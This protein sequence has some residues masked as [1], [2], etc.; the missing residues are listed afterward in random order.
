MKRTSLEK[1]TALIGAELADSPRLARNIEASAAD[2]GISPRTLARAK[3]HLGVRSHK[4]R[5]NGAWVW[6]LA[7]TPSSSAAIA[8]TSTAASRSAAERPEPA[9]PAINAAPAEAPSH[10]T[11]EPA[12]PL[13]AAPAPSASGPAEAG[14]AETMEAVHQPAQAQGD[15]AVEGHAGSSGLTSAV[16]ARPRP[17]ADPAVSVLAAPAHVDISDDELDA[18]I[19]DAD[20]RLASRPT[21]APVPRAESPE[22]K[23][24]LEE[25]EE[26]EL[27]RFPSPF[28]RLSSLEE[29]PIP[30]ASAK[31]EPLPVGGFDDHEAFARDNLD[32]FDVDEAR[33]RDAGVVSTVRP[34]P[35]A[36]RPT[37]PAAAG[38]TACA[39][40]AEVGR[41]S[42]TNG[43]IGR[44]AWGLGPRLGCRFPKPG[45]KKAAGPV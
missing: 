42:V 32:E 22:P 24:D 31:G 34:S 25:S 35:T 15:V 2:A 26:P 13:P 3:R 43:N 5:G 27:A 41:L 19:A 28:D 14:A 37:M 30:W 16:D 7:S 6:A 39:E 12:T 18:L 38:P 10:T 8:A 40:V 1:A 4:Q 45:L 20:A 23:L 29:P 17:V 33:S 21:A 44:L 36:Q 9:A 11:P